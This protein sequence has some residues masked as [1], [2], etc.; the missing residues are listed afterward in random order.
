M[1]GARVPGEPGGLGGREMP[2]RLGQVPL[3]LQ[4]GRLAHQQVDPVGQGQRTVAPAGVHHERDALTAPR[5]AHLL[6]VHDAAVHGHAALAPKTADVRAAHTESR[7]PF[8]E[9]THPVR[10]LD[11]PA[12]RVDRVVQ[13]RREQPEPRPV[14]DDSE[15]LGLPGGG[16]G[17]GG[18]IGPGGVLGVSGGFGFGDVLGVSEGS[19]PGRCRVCC[20]YRMRDQLGGLVERRGAP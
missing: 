16:T 6:Q 20:R 11:P 9:Q 2:V 10:L 12:E 19:G 13:C 8:G 1:P 5:R 4:V 3:G 15:T 7:Q 14:V 17:P 18:L